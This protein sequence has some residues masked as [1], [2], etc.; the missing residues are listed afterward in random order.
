MKRI[1]L[2]YIVAATL[3]AACSAQADSYTVTAVPGLTAIA[4]HLD[5]GGNTLQEV[6]PNVPPGS[7]VYKWDCTT[8]QAYVFDEFDLVWYPSDGTLAP[9]EG[10][11]FFNPSGAATTLTFTGTPHVPVLPAVLPC[12]CDRLNFLSR[13]TNGVGTYE[14]I[15]GKAPTEGALFIRF[16]SATQT[17]RTNVFSGGAWFPAVP[18]ANVGESVLMI[19]PCESASPYKWNQPPAPASPT[20]VYYGWNQ[21]SMDDFPPVAADDWVCATTNPVT[22]IRWW[23]SF[24]N[25][26]GTTPPQLPTVFLIR[27]WD[28]AP[29]GQ[30][31][32]WSH[33]RWQTGPTVYANTY[34]WKFV[35]WDYDPRS[36][37]Y[38]S[39]FLFE[40][41]LAQPDWF[42]QYP[43]YNGTNV[44]WI[45]IE[46][47]LQYP[48]NTWGWKTR[49]RDPTS[50]APDAA[51]TFDPNLGVPPITPI[52]SPGPTHQLL[53]PG[54]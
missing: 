22:K 14:N 19:I 30:Y 20:N 25:W 40:Q 11:L 26:Q 27:F 43:Q 7:V 16:D 17:Y 1:Q 8:W 37:R 42:Y 5:N 50:P 4:N 9:G 3:I 21:Q 12:G 36:G 2:W 15:T 47:V 34:T 31:L 18:T 52:R 51:V 46:A 28:D 39:C 45:S 44:F 38:E 23:G 53:G 35:G 13:Q 6:L 10:A 33:P 54:L 29:A 32:P 24:M 48:T 49:P 41:A